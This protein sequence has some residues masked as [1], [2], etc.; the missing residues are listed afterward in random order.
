[1]STFSPTHAHRD[2]DRER[3]PSIVDLDRAIVAPRASMP[4]AMTC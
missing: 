2:S 4:P 1:M 3:N